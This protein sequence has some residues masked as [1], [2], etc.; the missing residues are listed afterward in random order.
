MLDRDQGSDS[1]M[2]S[3]LSSKK[4]QKEAENTEQEFF[5]SFL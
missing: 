4:E 2:F 3:K 5:L 1:F